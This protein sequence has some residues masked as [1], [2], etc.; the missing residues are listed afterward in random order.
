MTTVS[1]SVTS[2]NG[3][4]SASFKSPARILEGEESAT[5]DALLSTTARHVRDAYGI[6][7]APKAVKRPEWGNVA[8]VED[9]RRSR[10][11]V[12]QRGPITPE[13]FALTLAV[14]AERIEELSS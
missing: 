14:A 11:A 6:V 4:V 13:D 2:P 9:L 3:D 8:L 5:I 10:L 7:S 1:I 12:L